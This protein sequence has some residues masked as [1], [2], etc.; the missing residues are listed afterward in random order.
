MVKMLSLFKLVV[1][2]Q[3]IIP[4]K[5]KIYL[6]L[7]IG[8]E[9]ALMILFVDFDGVLHPANAPVGADTDF[10]CLPLL[11]DWLRQYMQVN[12]VISSSW[13]ELMT[14]EKLRKLFS[15][16]IRHRVVDVCPN[17]PREKEFEFIRHAEILAWLENSQHQ[18]P[19][20][21][22]DDAA[23]LFPPSCKELIVC[24][25]DIGIDT[26]VIEVLTARLKGIS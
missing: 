19:W 26:H 9:L 20:L 25:R 10:C 21:A 5:G 12:I 1:I 22:L 17:L 4:I 6:T 13:R 7:L 3:Y 16:D 11:E 14:I 15:E 23:H 18:G 8:Y 24:Q 2:N